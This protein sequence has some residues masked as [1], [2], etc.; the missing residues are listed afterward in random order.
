MEYTIT[1]N[2]N[3]KLILTFHSIPFRSNNTE[4]D[5]ENESITTV[6]KTNPK[7][8]DKD[9]DIPPHST[10]KVGFPSYEG[11]L[12]KIMGTN[13]LIEFEFGSDKKIHFTH[14]SQITY[15]FDSDKNL[16]ELNTM[17]HS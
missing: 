12:F 2:S 8:K 5:E 7:K 4:N 13:S 16:I 6:F 10:C 17:I 9:Y 15:T 3:E 11:T 1:N 14:V